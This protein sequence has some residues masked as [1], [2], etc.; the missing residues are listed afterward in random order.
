MH[1]GFEPTEE[2][3][4][5]RN[6]KGKKKWQRKRQIQQKYFLRNLPLSLGVRHRLRGAFPAKSF[7]P[8]LG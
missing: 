5:T 3:P 7:Q 1:H 2:F 6:A 4:I 8:H